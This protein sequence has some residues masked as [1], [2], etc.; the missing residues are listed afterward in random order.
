MT[1][2]EGTTP[3]I[4]VGR[5]GLMPFA[6]DIRD[7]TMY[8]IDS[9][10]VQMYPCETYMAFSI[11]PIVA[12]PSG[13]HTGVCGSGHVQL[14]RSC[15]TTSYFLRVTCATHAHGVQPK[16]GWEVSTFWVNP[17]CK[18]AGSS[19]QANSPAFSALDHCSCSPLHPKKE[20]EDG[21]F[22]IPDLAAN[23]QA[24]EAS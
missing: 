17:S 1:S 9:C 24:R 5:R 18:H 8:S 7:Y 2:R 23:L 16:R 19:I 20:E 12:A 13:N 6:A 10:I 22:C 15:N 14:S 21:A 3:I 11:R 4:P